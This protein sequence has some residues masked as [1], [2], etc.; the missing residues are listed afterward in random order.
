[1]KKVFFLLCIV[2][3]AIIFVAATIP[4]NSRTEM[5]GKK[6]TACGYR[7]IEYGVGIDCNGDTVKLE[8]TKGFQTISQSNKNADE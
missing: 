5:T 2:A 7:I 4:A 6:N 3:M 8:R 1:M